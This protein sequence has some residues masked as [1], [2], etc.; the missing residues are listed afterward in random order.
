MLLGTLQ[1]IYLFELVF[2][3]S[4]DIYP[5]VESLYHVVILFLVFWGTSVQFSTVAADPHLLEVR[6]GGG[7]VKLPQQLPQKVLVSWTNL[8][9]SP[10]ALRSSAQWFVHQFA[11]YQCPGVLC[12]LGVGVLNEVHVY[13][14]EQVETTCYH[15][16][17]CNCEINHV[18]QIRLLI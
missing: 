15:F 18:T 8:G 6:P 4:L 5:R 1:C 12:I 14:R 13:L 10:A 3:F 16:I 7:I 2:S 11:I 9:I 17:P